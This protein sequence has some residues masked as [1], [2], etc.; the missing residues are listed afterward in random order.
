M[1]KSLLSFCLIASVISMAATEGHITYTFKGD[2]S[3]KPETFIETK[4]K[5]KDTG[6]S[7]GGKFRVKGFKKKANFF[8]FFSSFSVLF[9]IFFV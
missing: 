7:F 5:V 8:A 3:A 1:K 2:S 4:V 9:F 6:L